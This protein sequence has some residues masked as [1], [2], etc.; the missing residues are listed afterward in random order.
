[1]THAAKG[2]IIVLDGND[3]SGKETQSKLLAERFRKE[4]LEVYLESFP[5]Y[6]KSKAGKFI[7]ELLNGE[8]GSIS[9]L[10]P[11]LMSVPYALDRVGSSAEILQAVSEGRV[12]I[13]DRF[14]SSN[15]MHQGGKIEDEQE[16]IAFLKWLDELEHEELGIPRSDCVVYLKVPVDISVK[17]LKE[18][19]AAK[20]GSLKEGELDQVESDRLYLERSHAMANWLAQREQSWSVIDCTNE[21]GDM[22]SREEIAE[23]IFSSVV[24][25]L[26]A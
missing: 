12:V 26:E 7:G 3:G 4:G 9:T 11:E 14:T 15:Q 1:M 10:S 23:D 16:R 21:S 18:K 24:R 22:R 2:K 20:N 13:L 5:R 17:L 8:H 6:K 25:Q 19:R